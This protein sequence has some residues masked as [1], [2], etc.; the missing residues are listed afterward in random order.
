MKNFIRL[1]RAE[2]W[3]KNILILI[4]L[5]FSGHLLNRPALVSA[6]GATGLFCL[7]ASCVYIFNDIHD[8]KTDK[9]HKTKKNRPLAAGHIPP[10]TAWII[11]GLL[12]VFF[13]VGLYFFCRTLPQMAA[14]YLVSILVAYM[15]INIFYS[16]G[17][18]NVPI[19]E[20]IMV[21]S[22]F[23][24]RLMVGGIAAGVILSPWILMCVGS[25]AMTL[26]LGKRRANIGHGSVVEKKSAKYDISFL[27]K[28]ITQFSGITIVTYMLFC[29]S[30]YAAIRY[31]NS[32]LLTIIPMIIGMMRYD[33]II[34][35]E[36][37]GD[38][39]IQLFLSDAMLRYSVVIWFL[40]FGFLLY[41]K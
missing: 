10:T 35:I 29:F 20:L 13:S 7:L 17:M 39:P 40:I 5:F 8:A 41:L 2:Q 23:I 24:F 4:P 33:Q 19:L 14:E 31:G 6:L 30:G 27:D 28:M 12:S 37:G 25:G 18:K 34:L 1:I 36:N 22:G 32:V 16:M 38:A 11:L 21:A 9:Q 15:A 3:L 26:V